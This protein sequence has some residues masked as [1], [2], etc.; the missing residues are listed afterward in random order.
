MASWTVSVIPFFF[1]FFSCFDKYVSILSIHS[2]G[3]SSRIS[4]VLDFLQCWKNLSDFHGSATQ[5][6]SLHSCSIS[7]K[8][9]HCP[10]SAFSQSP[11]EPHQHDNRFCEVSKRV[12]P[13]CIIRA[14]LP[15]TQRYL[16][17]F[18]LLL[19]RGLGPTI[20]HIYK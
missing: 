17:L 12:V 7:T 6:V 1:F 10:V 16:L 18:V 14:R 19:L 11:F 20:Y 5:T 3:S 9:K 2:S 8:S 15:E 13:V 4:S